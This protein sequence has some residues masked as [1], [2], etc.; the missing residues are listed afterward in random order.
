MTLVQ[1]Q[2]VNFNSLRNNI[3]DRL[4]L[5][6]YFFYIWTKTMLKSR[7]PNKPA[8]YGRLSAGIRTP[9]SSKHLGESKLKLIF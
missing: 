9:S 1:N 8:F 6:L 4:F 5:A 7:L 3:L 2:C